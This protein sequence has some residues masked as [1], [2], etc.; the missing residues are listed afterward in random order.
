M[1]VS[2][3]LFQCPIQ[4]RAQVHGFRA[5]LMSSANFK[6]CRF[7]CVKMNRWYTETAIGSLV[8]H[9]R[10]KI[11]LNK[12]HHSR[13]SAFPTTRMSP[14]TATSRALRSPELCQLICEQLGSQDR[15]SLYSLCLSSKTFLEP[16]LDG[17]WYKLDNLA[18]LVRCM[19]KDLYQQ[20]VQDG[21][22]VTL[23]SFIL[24]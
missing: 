8:S 15:K 11:C 23:V 5:L 3:F 17:L 20:G 12:Y 19:P 13:P 14:T 6:A 7:L 4:Q 22:V 16:A 21:K 10:H 2:D 24:L 1:A 18:P 9:H